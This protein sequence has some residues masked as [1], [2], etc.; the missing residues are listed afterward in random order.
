MAPPSF[1][2][3]PTVTQGIVLLIAG[4]AVAT[5]GLGSL[6]AAFTTQSSA[7]WGPLLA[8]VVGATVFA[9]GIMVTLIALMR[10]AF[11]K[12]DVDDIVEKH[13]PKR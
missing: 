7:P 3:G 13:W 1:R 6:T 5:P 12:R 4:V 11:E 8:L 10:P 2:H 9:I